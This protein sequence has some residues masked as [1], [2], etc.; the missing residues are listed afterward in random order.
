M[1]KYRCGI[2]AGLVVRNW[3]EEGTSDALLPLIE[4][5]CR[6]LHPGSSAKSRVTNEICPHEP[7]SGRLQA[8][9]VVRGHSQVS[10]RI[11]TVHKL[12]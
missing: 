1:H 7:D 4:D 5:Q 8:R 9:R 6:S 12:G 11:R 3:H 10:I 2:G